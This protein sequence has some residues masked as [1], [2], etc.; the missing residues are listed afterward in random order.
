MSVGTKDLKFRVLAQ[1]VG[2]AAVSALK[3]N[4]DKLNKS[5]SFLSNSLKG[6]AA[7]YSAREAIQFGQSLINM[8]DNL[9]KL[10][11][12]TGVSVSAL[13]ALQEQAELADVP[14]DSLATGLRKLSL[15]LVEAAGGSQET[16]AVF[17]KLGITLRQSDGSVRDS[18]AVLLELQK[19]F[20][21]MK[22]GPE[23]AAL[24]V[25]LFG[26]SGADFIPLLNSSA[27][28]V[29]RLAQ[30]MDSDF[31]ARSE[32]FNDSL[33]ALGN[34]LKADAVDGLKV[35][36]PT[37]QDIADAFLDLTN[38]SSGSV[39]FFEAVGETARLTA[40]A[41]ALLSGDIQVVGLVF[42]T[43]AKQLKA[44][45]KFDFAEYG[46]LQ[47]E[48]VKQ[49]LAI[50]DKAE[51][52]SARIL[53]NSLIFGDGTAAEIRDR[54]K[55]S[56]APSTSN[57]PKGPAPDASELG[58]GQSVVRQLEDKI[59][60]VRAETSA[61][62]QSNVER[63]KAVFLAEAEAKGLAKTGAA[64][65]RL[66]ADFE[67]AV[68]AREV[69][70]EKLAAAE[71]RDS[72]REELELRRLEIESL[73]MSSVEY[74]K[75]VETR[76]S[77][78]DVRKTT[79]QFTA[80]GAAISREE[81]DAILNQRLALIEL[82][83]QQKRTYSAGAKQALKDYLEA[84]QDTSSQVRDLFAGAF[85]NMEDSLVN[86]VKTGE[87]NFRK[88]ADDIINEIIRIQIRAA[89]ANTIIGVGSLFGGAAAGAGGAAGAGAAAGGGA[90]GGGAVRAT[91][92]AKGGVMTSEGPLPLKYYANGGVANSPQLA[93]FGE[94]RK[95]EAYVP[96]PD[97]R[98]IPVSMRGGGGNVVVNLTVN[99]TTGETQS[100]GDAGTSANQ[101]ART[102]ETA[103]KNLIV[104]EKRPGGLLA[105][106]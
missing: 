1:V 83:D 54:V 14:F 87:L 10:S 44:A 102:L 11:Q 30:A 96:L 58:S 22:D 2:A 63:E 41:I 5:S 101:F 57:K 20:E 67:D 33:T 86:F 45:A 98:S 60:K 35:L 13:A 32:R 65:R 34:N 77:D 61:L 99:T 89:I 73:N 7:A 72:Q 8:G 4:F 100:S 76:K 88:F 29:G 106:S 79:K 36:L 12:K 25:K 47:D 82:E 43:T 26:K 93:V 59:R 81:A 92:F 91:P 94:G 71:F 56:T 37:L 50:V 39:G 95:P 97:G 64:Y 27:E 53:K 19:R 24:A 40:S 103:V 84:A 6:L 17:Q 49:R 52:T 42:T 31:A 78:N 69:G 21:K 104:K 16:A 15:N 51:K 62:G 3:D 74:K 75:L 18:G 38:D 46:R 28:S 70:K 9:N 66:G 48:A 68:R 23:K 80:E 55:R 85:R 90:A 105:A